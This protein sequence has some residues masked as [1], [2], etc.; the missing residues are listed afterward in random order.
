MPEGTG[1]GRLLEQLQ[2]LLGLSNR[3]LARLARIPHG[4]VVDMVATGVATARE[5]EEVSESIDGEIYYGSQAAIHR[6]QLLQAAKNVRRLFAETCEKAGVDP[7][8]TEEIG[9]LDL[10]ID[11][12]EGR[13][14]PNPRL[15]AEAGRS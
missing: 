1:A 13:K 5:W 12:A 9:L 3:S 6:F 14:N 11:V 4:R 15:F 8:S 10:A 7:L 2:G